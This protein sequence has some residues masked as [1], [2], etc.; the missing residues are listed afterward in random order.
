MIDEWVCKNSLKSQSLKWKFFQ[1]NKDNSE[2]EHKSYMIGFQEN[3]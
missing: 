1:C 3:Y 2:I